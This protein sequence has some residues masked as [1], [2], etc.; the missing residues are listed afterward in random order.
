MWRFLLLLF[1]PSIQRKYWCEINVLITFL[2]CTF[3]IHTIS[4]NKCFFLFRSF[5]LIKYS[6]T[7]YYLELFS[8]HSAI[9]KKLFINPDWSL[10]F[11]SQ[12]WGVLVFFLYFTN[13]FMQTHKYLF[14]GFSFHWFF[15]VFHNKFSFIKSAKK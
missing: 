9:G 13:S 14:Y 1:T 2:W 5:Y 11:N 7:H 12:L 15:F 10:N 8:C 3:I 4:F 6:I